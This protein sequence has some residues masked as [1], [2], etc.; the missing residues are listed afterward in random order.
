[1]TLGEHI[2][3]ARE[4][5]GLSARDLA[6]I[7]GVVPTYISRIEL[8]RDPTP[9]TEAVVRRIAQAVGAD[10]EHMLW[11][12]G[13]VPEWVEALVLADPGVPALLEAMRRHKVKAHAVRE[14]VESGA[15]GGAS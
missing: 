8:G 2:R 9:P 3:D 15:A 7:V 5:A 12:A 10:A 6:R 1:M 13:R 11:L 14:L 4:R